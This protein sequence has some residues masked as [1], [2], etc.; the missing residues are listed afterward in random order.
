MKNFHKKR[1]NGAK[2]I[3]IQVLW[4]E[5]EVNETES[6]GKNQDTTGR[7]MDIICI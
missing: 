2:I 4:R 1:V 5:W 3:E 7:S 6:E